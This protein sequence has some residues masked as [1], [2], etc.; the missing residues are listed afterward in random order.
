MVATGDRWLLFQSTG[1][2]GDTTAT[3]NQPPRLAR[4]LLLRH[5]SCVWHVV[6]FFSQ[7]QTQP[8][9]LRPLPEHV[10]AKS[11]VAKGHGWVGRSR[12]R[13]RRHRQVDD[14]STC[15]LWLRC[16]ALLRPDEEDEAEHSDGRATRCARRS[17][18][19]GGLVGWVPAP[20]SANHVFFDTS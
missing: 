12:S 9:V 4:W 16:F 18:E 10:L 3:R 6:S 5:M 13:R 8:R 20:T 7:H 19:I 17:K 1:H 2:V 14:A 15:K 11:S